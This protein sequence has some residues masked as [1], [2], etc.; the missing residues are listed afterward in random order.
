MSALA[1]EYG[2]RA[3]AKERVLA[4]LLAASTAGVLNT[5]LNT[6]CYRYGAR[7]FELIREGYRI[8][9]SHVAKGVWRYTLL[10]QERLF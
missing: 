2:R 3:T 1:D 6:I 7:V 8:E 4:R 9:R 5:D 10:P